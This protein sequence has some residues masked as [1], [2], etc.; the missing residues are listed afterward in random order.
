MVVWYFKSPPNDL[1]YS[2]FMLN[3]LHDHILFSVQFAQHT[4]SS[5]LGVETIDLITERRLGIIFYVEP[6]V[7]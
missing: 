5:G 7:T 3:D 6:N 2:S 4:H 1:L